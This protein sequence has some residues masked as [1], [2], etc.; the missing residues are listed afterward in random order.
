[1][2]VVVLHYGSEEDTRR[3]LASALPQLKA[4]DRLLVVWNR[5]PSEALRA[6]AARSEAV[7]ALS[8]GRNLGFAAGAN[9]ALR[10]G[11]AGGAALLLLLNN[12]ATLSPGALDRLRA[13]AAEGPP[14][15][16][17]APVVLR[18]DGRVWAA[19]GR[20]SWWT[21][22]TRHV[23][24]GEA[25]GDGLAASR[26]DYLVGCALAIPRETLERVGFLD[27]A[28]FVYGEDVDLSLRVVRAGLPL[29]VV[30]D[31]LVTHA[32]RGDEE[33]ASA[34]R[35]YLVNRNK[36]LLVRRYGAAWRRPAFWLLHLAGV[37]RRWLSGLLRGD[38]AFR[39]AAWLG[40]RDGWRGV[41]GPP[42]ESV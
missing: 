16:L 1:M 40:L 35:A 2:A 31:A 11:L 30:P 23:G 42:P 32:A 17:L 6:E 13:A 29:R 33:R 37:A 24:E 5:E 22:R 26:A 36:I 19:A 4:G 38:A 14:P 7:R 27:E 39:R 21:G 41:G 10:E 15:G 3:C 18:P 9:L 25:P 12:D 34:R 8:P 20:V 28:L